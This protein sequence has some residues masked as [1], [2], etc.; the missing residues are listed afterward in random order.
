MS[1][2]NEFKQSLEDWQSLGGLWDRAALI[3]AFL[4]KQQYD[5]PKALLIQFLVRLRRFYSID[6]CS[7]GL[8]DG[9]NLTAAAVP[10]AGLEQ[11]PDNLAR[12]CLNLV[13]HARAP[14]TW[15]EVK[16]EFGFRSMVVAP[17]APPSAMPVGFLMLGHTSRRVY[18]AA[19]LFVLQSLASELAWVARELQIQKE[20]RVEIADLSHDT[21]N[22]LQLIVGYTALIRQNLNGVLGREQEQFFTNLE[23][24]VDRI[25]RQLSQLP[26]VHAADEG[27]SEIIVP[28]AVES[29]ADTKKIAVSKRVR[30]EN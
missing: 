10:E 2:A 26:T 1:T 16:A 5:D 9:E 22:T 15:N 30:D 21:K 19:E 11:L 27:A 17:I 14:I 23:S 24:D 12:R 4:W 8:A 7:A 29:G 3:R 6:F 13:A 20:H 25:L 28:M 18:S